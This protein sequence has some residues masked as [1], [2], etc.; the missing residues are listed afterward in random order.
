LKGG[1]NKADQGEVAR[2]YIEWEG[3]RKK[4]Q[5]VRGGSGHQLMKMDRKHHS[6]D[7]KDKIMNTPLPS[8]IK[9]KPNRNFS[10]DTQQ[11]V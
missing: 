4:E 7:G 2:H 8:D 3:I 1:N 10:T 9:A 5:S 6:K 11:V